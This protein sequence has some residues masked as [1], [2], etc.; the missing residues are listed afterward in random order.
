MINYCTTAALEAMLK[1]VPV[2]YINSAVYPL[3]DWRDNLSINGINRVSSIAELQSVLNNILLNKDFRV[4]SLEQAK[5]QIFEVLVNSE[6]SASER[7]N[8]FI[9]EKLTSR[10]MIKNNSFLNEGIM[11]KF[12]IDNCTQ[13]A[14]QLQELNSINSSERLKLVLAY[15]AGFNNLG[16]EGI[17]S[18][19]RM[20]NGSSGDTYKMIETCSQRSL[21]ASYISGRLQNWEAEESNMRDL[22]FIVP[23]LLFPIKFTNLDSK[24][25]SNFYKYLLQTTGELF[26]R[27][28]RSNLN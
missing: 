8:N 3:E 22:L 17:A 18:I 16:L 6:K 15:L 26:S 11:K 5:G 20:N 27:Q 7:I 19:S 13:D 9:R 10:P 25:R 24:E 21:V 4:N 23:Y 14:Y 28:S 2:V 12:L 1:K